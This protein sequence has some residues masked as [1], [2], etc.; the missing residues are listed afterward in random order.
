MSES[1][2]RI[3]N[4]GPGDEARVHKAEN[5]FDDAVDLLAT[6]AFLADEHHH[7]LIAYVEGEPAGFVSAVEMFHPDKPQPEM[8]LNELGVVPAFRRR[9]IATSLIKELLQLCKS[10]GC[11]EMW[12]LTNEDNTPAMATYHRTGARRDS[13]YQ[14]MFTYGID[15]DH[16][17]AFRS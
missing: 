12:V 9:G 17:G 7:L 8:F 14:V 5:V 16:K 13:Q 3:V 10:K 15:L 2:M 6:E 1:P 4:M 11:S